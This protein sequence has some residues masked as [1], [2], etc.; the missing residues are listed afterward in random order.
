MRLPTYRLRHKGSKQ[1]IVVNQSDYHANVAAWTDW[2]RVGESRGEGNEMIVVSTDGSAAGEKTPPTPT[3]GGDD[4]PAKTGDGS[5]EVSGGGKDAGSADGSD[6]FKDMTKAQLEKYAKE[7]FG[8]D[9]DRRHSRADLEAQV[10]DLN[11]KVNKVEQAAS[12]EPQA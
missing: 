4:G 2:V 9:L 12:G 11:K 10:R 6:E 8:V 1:E 3:E 5:P 7:T